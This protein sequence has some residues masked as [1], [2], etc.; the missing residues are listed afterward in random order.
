MNCC[1]HKAIDH[2]GDNQGIPPGAP[3]T[4]PDCECAGYV[5]R[6]VRRATGVVARANELAEQGLESAAIAERLGVSVAFA[7]YAR[8]RVRSL[9]G[10]S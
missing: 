3:C 4:I 8:R 6:R 1:Q 7:S 10:P 2:E 5:L 9:R